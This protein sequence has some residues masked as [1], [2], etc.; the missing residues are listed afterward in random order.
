[1]RLAAA[2]VRLLDELFE[3]ALEVLQVEV[4]V[5]DLIH[6]DGL[7][8]S[9]R[10]ARRFRDRL[11]DLLDR[12]AGDREHDDEGHL[13]LRAR[14]LEVEALLFVAE[15][16]DVA[17]FEAASADRAVVEPRAVADELDDAHRDPILRPEKRR[18]S[19]LTLALDAGAAGRSDD[20]R[21]NRAGGQKHAVSRLEVNAPAFRL[22]HEGDRSVDAVE[23]LLVGVAVR[24]V[25]VAGPIRP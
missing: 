7:R 22:E 16:L 9:R 5:D 4:E 6:C 13:A 21:M 2:G 25:P 8:R 10:V 15:D 20:R 11:L 24:R 12:P 14:D 18:G 3:S 23:D 19:V 1:M 17:T